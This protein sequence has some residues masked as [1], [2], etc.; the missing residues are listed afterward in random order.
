MPGPKDLAE[1]ADP[2]LIPDFV[3]TPIQMS[4]CAQLYNLLRNLDVAGLY[5][6]SFDELRTHA[7]AKDEVDK[8]LEHL[9]GNQLWNSWF[10]GCAQPAQGSH[11]VPRQLISYT[12][13]AL[14]K[15]RPSFDTSADVAMMAAIQETVA[16]MTTAAKKRKADSDDL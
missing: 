10:V 2:A 12:M 16:I 8:L 3:P 9:L 11:L 6:V 13:A 7:L 1:G 15:L 4:G 5:E 14:E